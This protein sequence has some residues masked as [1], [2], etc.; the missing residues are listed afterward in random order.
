MKKQLLISLAL[1]TLA[2]A[3]QAHQLWFERD[4]D[5]AARI[6]VGDVD[7]AHDSGDEV[8][9]LAGTTLV[10]H[11]DPRAKLDVRPQHDHLRVEA[12]GTRDI[13]LVNEQVWKPWKTKTG[14]FKAA[15]FTARE[16]RSEAKGALDWEF[17][18]LAPGSN[19]FTLMFKGQ[20]LAGKTVTVVDAGKWSRRLKTGPDGRVVVPARGNGRLVLIAAHTAAETRQLGDTTVTEID[21]VTTLSFEARP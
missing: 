16:G 15:V 9:Q 3:A 12:A 11:E 14:S 19:E 13:R 20:A 5:G 8:R 7:D 21:Y 10:F 6:R 18:P 2:A 1:A 17:V 4:A